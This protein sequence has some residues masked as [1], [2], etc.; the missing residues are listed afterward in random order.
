M[1]DGKTCTDVDECKENPRI[2]NGGKCTNTIG[3]Y[4]CHCTA[5]LLPGTGGVSCLGN[6]VIHFLKDI[7]FFVHLNFL[8]YTLLV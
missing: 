2:C 6:N 4:I 5:G 7:N 1:L 3:S 8:N